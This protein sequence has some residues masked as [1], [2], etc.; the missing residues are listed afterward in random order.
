MNTF[1]W[2]EKE[3][4]EEIV[5]KLVGKVDITRNPKGDKLA[6]MSRIVR[7]ESPADVELYLKH[8]W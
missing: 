7:P 2:L 4:E 1:P 6:R 5:N 3:E 8:K